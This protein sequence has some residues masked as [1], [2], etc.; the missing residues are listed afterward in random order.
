MGW[1][2]SSGCRLAGW[3]ALHSVGFL[4]AKGQLLP[5]WHRHAR[6]A[7]PASS[8]PPPS[9]PAGTLGEALPIARLLGSSVWG[10]VAAYPLACLGLRLLLRPLLPWL[11][12]P[13]GYALAP[14]LWLLRLA[15][16]QP[17]W[18]ASLPAAG[19]LLW[20]AVDAEKRGGGTPP[21]YWLQAFLL[22]AVW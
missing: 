11:A 10:H 12:A 6:H 5:P 4:R 14:P 7:C 21:G 9:P 2:A 18:W 20:A 8:P 22:V 19:G 17:R 3:R 1:G 15:V 13:A 16:W